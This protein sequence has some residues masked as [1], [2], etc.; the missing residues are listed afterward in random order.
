VNRKGDFLKFLAM[1]TML[2]DHIG[3]LFFPSQMIWRII[4]RLSFPIFA[5]LIARGYR[6]TSS[7]VNY[8]GRLFIFGLLSQIPYIYFVPGKL[9][10]MFTLFVG[11]LIIEIFES[12]FKIFI[13]PLLAL[14]HFLP[15]S[16]GVY[17]LA[18]ILIFHTTYGDENKTMLGYFLLSL[19]AYVS[20]ENSIQAMSVFALF[21]ILLDPATKVKVP[22]MVGYLFY[23]G[24]I[25][26]LLLIQHFYFI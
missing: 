26:A 16:Y 11:L 25:T 3:Y 12:R 9:N 14:G 6:Y 24:H 4:G 21:P 18:M 8:A 23:P 20:T 10:I 2:I 15:I 1:L 17:G 5:F 13:I 19:F 7:K 22:R